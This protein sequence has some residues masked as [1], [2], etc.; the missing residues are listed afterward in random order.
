MERIATM[1]AHAED[2]VVTVA[3]LP[4]VSELGDI[5]LAVR[6]E[7]KDPVT[8]SQLEAAQ[9]GRSVPEVLRRAFNS[10]PGAGGRQPCQRLWCLVRRGV[11]DDD[12]L[13][14]LD[15]RNEAALEI[16][17]ELLDHGSFVVDRNDDREL[18]PRVEAALDPFRFSRLDPHL[19]TI[20]AATDDES[21]SA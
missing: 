15:K 12:H 20:I 18:D 14:A 19:Q 6:V 8:L 7:L 11:I 10:E 13:Q 1:A 16:E 5:D 21:N 17:D 9:N 3:L 2:Q 4:E